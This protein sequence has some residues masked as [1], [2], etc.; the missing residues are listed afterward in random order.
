MALAV[1]STATPTRPIGLRTSVKQRPSGSIGAFMRSMSACNSMKHSPVW[2][3]VL[4]T[5]MFS[6]DQST[7]RTGL[8][9]WV[10]RASSRICR[11]ST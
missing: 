4:S 11:N 8:Q 9:R 2:N 3:V 1:S 7:G 5:L 10:S 6:Y